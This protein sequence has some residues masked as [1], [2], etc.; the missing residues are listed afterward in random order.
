MFD[1]TIVSIGV[2]G[3]GEIAS[4]PS[5]NVSDR[6]GGSLLFKCKRNYASSLALSLTSMLY[7]LIGQYVA[8]RVITFSWGECANMS[9]CDF[10]T[11]CDVVTKADLCKARLLANAECGCR[12][13]TYAVYYLPCTYFP[14]LLFLHNYSFPMHEYQENISS[15]RRSLGVTE[16]VSE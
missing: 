12:P 2:I 8:V 3:C 7:Q 16:G 13:S 4:C 15:H 5:N 6:I 9:S 14:F 11:A 10:A 1:S